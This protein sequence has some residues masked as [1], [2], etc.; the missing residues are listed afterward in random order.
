MDGTGRDSAS[1]EVD[2]G[3]GIGGVMDTP[4]NTDE[5]EREV[6]EHI[7]HTSLVDIDITEDEVIGLP[8]ELAGWRLYRIGY[9]GCGEFCLF[10]GKVLLPPMADPDGIAQL[11]MG[12]EAQGWFWNGADAT[13]EQ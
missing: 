8:P 9:G 1:R 2:G 3:H 13:E 4:G 10:E 5:V 7:V 6:S 11:I 12:M